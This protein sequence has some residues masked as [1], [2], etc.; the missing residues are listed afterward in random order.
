MPTYIHLLVSAIFPIYTGAH[1]S[2]SRPSSAAKPEKKQK[3]S[4]QSSE[5]TESDAEDEVVV[6]KMEGLS[7]SDAIMFPLM[8][9]LTLGSLY[10]IIKWLKDP[11]L[12]N[13]ILRWYFSQM[14]LFFSIKF[15]KDMSS[16]ARSLVF[17]SE[18]VY[19]GQLWKV[20]AKKQQFEVSETTA[21]VSKQRIQCS[22]LPGLLSRFHLPK[23]IFSG[24]WSIREFM[25]AKAT[26]RFHIKSLFTVKT[27][28]EILDITSTAASIAIVIFSLTAKTRWWLT[29]YFGFAFCYGS[30][31]FMSPTTFWTGTLILS[32]LFLYD[33][34]FV[35]FTPLMVIVATKLDVPIKLLFPRPPAPDAPPDAVSLAMLGLGDIVIPG[36]MIGLALR[37]DLY[38]HYLRQQSSKKTG[39]ESEP[40]STVQKAKYL[41]ATG[42]WGER[43]WSPVS[44]DVLSSKEI[45]AA[46]FPKSYF[47][48][49][50]TG[51]L[52][53]MMT[54]LGV[55]QI[56][57]HAQPALLY[58][59]PGVLGSLWATALFKGEVK[60]MW[61]FTEA[62]DKEE[63]D[64]TDDEEGPLELLRSVLGFG[65][66]EKKETKV[67]EVEK[68]EG[69]QVADEAAG[70]KGKGTE[71][72]ADD[73]NGKRPQKDIS[74]KLIDFSI[75][76]PHS[77]SDR[78]SKKGNET[79][80]PEVPSSP[81]RVDEG[82][83]EAVTS[84]IEI[85]SG[86]GQQPS[87]KRTRAA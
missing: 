62:E 18:Y 48:A 5:G 56:A 58:L 16:I 27:P 44:K 36:M 38:L 9:G 59:V 82:L 51:Y 76:L 45:F 49:S 43:Y 20:S 29:N 87:V 50:I 46:R 25:Y 47:Y 66:K 11:A 41:Q 32:S 72:S 21:E 37:F 34:Y 84:G 40:E 13:K 85:G 12:L 15:L 52:A 61:N 31:Q 81:K 22:P 8:A 83:D 3:K 39:S 77:A 10:L 19:R 70:K 65:K 26:L 79:Q 57:E 14:G 78:S 69:K 68:K 1:A 53:G 86:D 30:L 23:R 55:M 64:G 24:L 60:E 80:S 17:P 33:I 74:R 6:Q 42:H 4:E 54:T 63:T 2:L 73:A 67:R 28:V 35:F 7:P 71:K 75:T